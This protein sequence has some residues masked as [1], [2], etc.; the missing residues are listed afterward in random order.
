MIL[1][2]LRPAVALSCLLATTS[3]WASDD[4]QPALP[5]F[6]YEVAYQHEIKPMRHS[7]PLDGVTSGTDQI[8]L[9]LT[10][11][12]AGTVIKAVPRADPEPLKFWP[13][14]QSEI[15]NWKFTP[16]EVDGKP[17][18]AEVE[19]YVALAPPERFPTKHVP[20]PVLRPDSKVTINLQRTVCYGR[21]PAYSV[22]VSTQ[23]IVFYGA[24]FVTA[25]GKHTAAV[26]ADQVRKLAQRFIDAD[27]YSMAPE[28]RA[29]VTDNSTYTLSITIDGHRKKIID[30]VGS[31]VGMPA[32]IN[33]LEDDVDTLAHSDRWI[34]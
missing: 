31:W 14:L 11:S 24:A 13:K 27:F 33:E 22:T 7:I 28:Y 30:Y 9:T 2:M 17:V 8:G 21:C 19:E 25:S 3:A 16:F 23:G 18:T 6:N 12:P 20:P 15:Y 29:T 34:R 32:I 1:D 10:V 26:D 5:S 4:K